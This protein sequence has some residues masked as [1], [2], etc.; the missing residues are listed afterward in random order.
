MRSNVLILV[1]FLF[2][3]MHGCQAQRYS[4]EYAEYK[5]YKSLKKALK[6]KSQVKVLQLH[7]KELKEFPMDVLELKGLKI[8][9]FYNNELTEIPDGIDQLCNLERLELMKNELSSLP[10]SIVNLK[11]LK[12]I[13]IAYN[14]MSE[15]DVEFIKQALPNCTIITTIIL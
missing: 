3:A 6:N 15:Q 7:N 5:V 14:G 1:V 12:R 10:K 13:N 4:G 8:L 2:I 9:S 11:R